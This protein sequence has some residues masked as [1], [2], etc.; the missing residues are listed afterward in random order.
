MDM[1]T[2]NINRKM[3]E[4]LK[5]LAERQART[6]PIRLRIGTVKNG[7][8]HHDCIEIED[9]PPT[10]LELLHNE[11]NEIGFIEIVRRGKYTLLF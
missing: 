10:A 4:T 11:N 7:T 3:S 9:A 2:M 6:A 1:N 8:V 5:K